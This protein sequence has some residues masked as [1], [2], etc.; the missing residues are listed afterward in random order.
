MSH[1]L[2]KIDINDFFMHRFLWVNGCVC[3]YLTDDNA[4][5]C[6]QAALRALLV[7]SLMLLIGCT[8][9]VHFQCKNYSSPKT[10]PKEIHLSPKYIIL[11]ASGYRDAVNLEPWRTGNITLDAPDPQH[12]SP[13]GCV[14]S[15][16]LYSLYTYDCTAV[17]HQMTLYIIHVRRT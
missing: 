9:Y 1:P 4:E 11:K 12:R 13:S 10:V 6:R 3:C 2:G 5:R 7:K 16:L 15:P 17:R 14:P 8:W